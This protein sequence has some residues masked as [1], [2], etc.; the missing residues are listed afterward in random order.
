M[1]DS[2]THGARVVGSLW[3]TFFDNFDQFGTVS[4]LRDNA[5]SFDATTVLRCF[6]RDK[7]GHENARSSY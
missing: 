2:P 1:K 5:M 3:K 7:R 4:R 6:L